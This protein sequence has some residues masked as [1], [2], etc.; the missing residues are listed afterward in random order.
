MPKI[1]D[2]KP[3]I[4][5]LGIHQGLTGSRSKASNLWNIAGKYPQINLILGG[6]NHQNAPGNVIGWR[7][8]YACAGKHGENFLEA[9]AEFD[10]ET[11]ETVF[12]SKLVPAS[13]YPED[14]ESA[15]LV[16]KSLDYV[17]GQ[18]ARK[19]GR[20]LSPVRKTPE[21]A[22]NSSLNEL[23]GRAVTSAVK[24]K[25]AFLGAP[26]LKSSFAGEI[27]VKTLYLMMP[28]ENKIGILELNHE[29][30]SEV[31][32]EQVK[33]AGKNIIQSPWGIYANIDKNG[34]MKDE[35]RFA[36]GSTWKNKEQKI[37]I[38]FDSYS[39]AG[40]GNRFPKLRKL[41]RS[42]ANKPLDSGILVR[43]ALLDYISARSPLRIK[44]IKWLKV[45]DE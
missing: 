2:N 3:D 25:V 27:T 45:A 19:V 22:L 38:A 4:V 1:A 17:A 28:Y 34:K 7:T 13:D 23:F 35:L 40:A 16:K 37:K 36:D 26:A 6:H 29:Q 5:I 33:G 32:T 8:W 10:T 18:E 15:K 43:K 12:T 11:R 24:V 31:I 14:P 30:V 41:A 9:N 39:L 42:A 20:F 44:K 21:G